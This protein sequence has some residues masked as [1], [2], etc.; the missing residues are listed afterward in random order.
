VV[1]LVTASV[2]A[3]VGVLLAAVA[4]R[5]HVRLRGDLGRGVATASIAGVV[6]RDLVVVAVAVAGV[7]LAVHRRRA[8]MAAQR[9]AEVAA[10]V[11][12][13]VDLFRLAAAAG[14]SVSGALSAVA[15]RAPP[16]LGPA[17]GD[18]VGRVARGLPLDDSLR[19]LSVDLGPGGESLVALLRHSAATGIALAPAMAELAARQRSAQRAETR[20]AIG[21]LTVTMV[22][23]LVCCI[24]PA[25]VVLAVVPVVIVSLSA[26]A[27]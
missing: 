6:T 9:A 27:G 1:G 21:R 23:P 18:A 14:L 12:E 26:L 19:Q 13:L 5:H 2:L 17:L 15:E 22:V 20:A 11:P 25:A 7:E 16:P 10:A 4:A 3:A 8:R 24:L